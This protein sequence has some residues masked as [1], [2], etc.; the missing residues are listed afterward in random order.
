MYRLFIILAA[1]TFTASSCTNKTGSASSTDTTNAAASNTGANTDMREKNKTTALAA[2][3]AVNN[4]DAEALFKDATPDFTDYGDGS[5][6]PVK[7]KDS[8][9]VFFQQG[10]TAFPDIKGENLMAIADGN[11]VAVFGDWSGTF[12]G[13]LMG[14]KPTNK[15]FKIKDVD[16]FTFNDQGQISEHRSIQSMTTILMQVGASMKK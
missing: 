7:G 5:V 16:L 12:K 8:C 13:K 4:H 3:E 14:M 9:K 10:L 1:I 15:S 11:H 2:E 6:P